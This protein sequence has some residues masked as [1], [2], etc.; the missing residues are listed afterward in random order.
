M[1][2][3]TSHELPSRLHLYLKQSP[4]LALIVRCEILERF[5][6]FLGLTPFRLDQEGFR[7]TVR[8][9][10]I[11]TRYGFEGERAAP[12]RNTCPEVVNLMSSRSG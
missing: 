8:S 3:L 5:E 2:S 6:V 11:D 7:V 10:V 1:S 4:H 12:S 9:S